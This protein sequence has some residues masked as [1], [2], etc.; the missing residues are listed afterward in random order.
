M[1]LQPDHPDF[2]AAAL[3]E[4]SPADLAAFADGVAE[5]EA[6]RAESDALLETAGRL[7]AALRQ[8]PARGFLTLEQR[9]RVLNPK[10]VPASAGASSLPEIRE[11]AVHQPAVAVA[12]AVAAAAVPG[13]PVFPVTPRPAAIRRA[14]RRPL[15]SRYGAWLASAGIAAVIAVGIFSVSGPGTPTGEGGTVGFPAPKAGSGTPTQ[16][17]GI[18]SI[19]LDPSAVADRKL[20]APAPGMPAIPQKEPSMPPAPPPV[21]A[22]SPSLSP[23][24]AIATTAP[25]IRL[26][27]PAA[28]QPADR[29]H[30]PEPDPQPVPGPHRGSAGPDR[31]ALA[32][33]APNGGR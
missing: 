20:E 25:E 21:V 30:I 14:A 26:A 29:T 24:D 6:W 31:G 27:P 16:A 5:N 10:T 12:A 7:T 19:A 28:P 11:T 22:P 18:P 4:A 33:P 8:E 2:T 3:G 23:A 1:S 17:A 15:P 32:S 9:E 13:Q